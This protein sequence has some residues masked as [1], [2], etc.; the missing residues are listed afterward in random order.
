MNLLPKLRANL[1]GVLI[2][3]NTLIRHIQTQSEKKWLPSSFD[4]DHTVSIFVIKMYSKL[5]TFPVPCSWPKCNSNPSL[6]CTEYMKKYSFLLKTPLEYF[7]VCGHTLLL[8]LNA[9]L[10]STV[11]IHQQSE[12]SRE[13]REGMQFLVITAHNSEYYPL[14]PTISSYFGLLSELTFHIK[15]SNSRAH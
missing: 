15:R 9:I 6:G 5:I 7:T 10:L 8:L 3:D 11:Y 4:M 13:A 14:I 12:I 2:R 1:I